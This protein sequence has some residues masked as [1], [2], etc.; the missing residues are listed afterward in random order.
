MS[1]GTDAAREFASVGDVIE[2]EVQEPYR[3][4]LRVRLITPEA[5]AYGNDLIAAGR[6]SKVDE[7]HRATDQNTPA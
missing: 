7:N 6:W 4:K 1:T 5:C 2:C 3:H